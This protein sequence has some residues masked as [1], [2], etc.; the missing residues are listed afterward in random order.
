MARPEHMAARHH[1]VVI[2]TPDQRVRVFVSST[3]GELAEERRAVRKAI[4]ELHL[5]PVMF[6]LGASVHP[7][8]SLYRSYLEQSHVFIG[9]YWQRY[10]WVAPDMEI[11]GLEDEYL[12]S[13]EKPRLIY[14]KRPAPEQEPR[15]GDLLDRIEQRGELSYKSFA[16]P[17]ELARLVVDDLAVLL[18]EAFQQA[19][20]PVAT[21]PAEPRRSVSSIPAEPNRFVGRTAELAT[22]ADLL[23]DDGVRAISLVGPGGIGKSRLAL[24]SAARSA[25]PVAFVPLANLRHPDEVPSSIAA[26]VGLR[27]TV[28]DARSLSDHLGST[29]LLMLLDNMEHVIDSSAWIAELL[30]AARNLRVLVTS[31]EPM[32]I[33]GEHEVVVAPMSMDDAVSLFT[34]RAAAAGGLPAADATE[35]VREICARV[36]GIPLAIELAAARARVLPPRA[37]LGRLNDALGFLRGGSRDA[38]ERLRALRSTL[39]WSHD[40][41]DDCE[42]S[43]FAALGVF[44]SSFS[45][46][47][48]EAVVGAAD[49]G[50]P[51]EMLASLVDKSL[52][53]VETSMH[54]ARFRLLSVVADYAQEK[55]SGASFADA[56]RH[57]HARFFRD[58]ATSC[59]LPLRGAQQRETIRRLDEETLNVRAAVAWL[60]DQDRYD[61]AARIAWAIWPYVWARTYFEEV[62]TLGQ[63]ALAGDMTPR[64]RARLLI[65]T[66][67]CAFWQG[68]VAS[69]LPLLAEAL[70]IGE[71]I[72]DDEIIGG[73]K[74]SQGLGMPFYA[75]AEE[76]RATLSE[77]LE[78]FQRHGNAWEEA[79]TTVAIL[80]LDAFSDDSTSTVDDYEQAVA[81]AR[82]LNDDFVAA[83]AETNLA[84][85]LNREGDRGRAIETLRSA[86]ERYRVMHAPYPSTN[87]VDLVATF[88]I[89]AGNAEEAARLM[90]AADGLRADMQV[91]LWQAMVPRRNALAERVRSALGDVAYERALESGRGLRLAQALD[92]AAEV[93][94]RLEAVSA[95]T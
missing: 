77:A 55:L 64:S 54:G 74:L 94:E 4:E 11:S 25:L 44:P 43:A 40:L 68:D 61:D 79:I 7:P 83:M 21:A 6:E 22:L 39:D 42:R 69:A 81:L 62:R 31:R 67:D 24:H 30:E 29:P 57:A 17:E 5:V 48:A 16:T 27:D 51:L 33:S 76:S 80:W 73:V 52:V 12:L 90:G 13:A 53:R 32:R 66:G 71:A 60:L 89:D 9:M 75:S 26:A 15:L 72:G 35:V 88:A 47:A 93:A 18:S 2:L 19:V 23:G 87:V 10:G 50:D 85:H 78:C 3:L 1:G 8:R 86:L 65:V 14:V 56:T 34:V 95:L 49:C 28:H 92:L 58:L 20:A 36:D 45:L 91:P 70:A 38:P 41:L 37:L 82:Q 46:E 59:E 63:A 84:D